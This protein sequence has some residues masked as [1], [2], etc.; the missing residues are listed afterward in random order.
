MNE[1]A[2]MGWGCRENLQGLG[3]DGDK[4]CGDGAGMEKTYI[5]RDGDGDKIASPSHSLDFPY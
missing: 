5:L 3:G 1:C 2:G 4:T